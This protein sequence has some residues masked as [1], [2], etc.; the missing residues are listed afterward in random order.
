MTLATP[1]ADRAPRGLLID[2]GGVLS[3][4]VFESFSVFEQAEGLE[5]GATVRL[6]LGDERAATLLAALETG[7]VTAAGFQAEIGALLGVAPAGL[8]ARMFATMRPEPAMLEAVRGLR[9]AGVRTALVSNSWGVDGYPKE[10]FRDLFD[11]VVISGDVGLRK[12]DPEIYLLAAAKIGLDP[13]ECVF[14]DDLPGNLKPAARLGMAVI[15]HTA[16]AATIAELAAVF[17]LDPDALET[18]SAGP[19]MSR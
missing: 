10:L 2:Y 12:P 7:T 17:G 3:T 5:R 19:A 1:P 13:A 18:G 9:R 4:D 16:A 11:A 15:R 6:L 8:L 14:V